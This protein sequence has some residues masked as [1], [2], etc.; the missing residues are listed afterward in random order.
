MT[1]RNY[2][3]RLKAVGFN[4]MVPRAQLIAR[5]NE[6]ERERQVAREK[7]IAREKRILRSQ[8]KRF[9]INYKKEQPDDDK[10]YTELMEKFNKQQTPPVNI[11]YLKPVEARWNGNKKMEIDIQ[12]SGIIKIK[13][14]KPINNGDFLKVNSNDLWKSYP[15]IVLKSI[16]EKMNVSN[17]IDGSDYWNDDDND[18]LVDVNDNGYLIGY[19]ASDKINVSIFSQNI[20]SLNK[21]QMRKYEYKLPHK[22]ID[23]FIDSGD[24][25]CFSEWFCQKY[26]KDG[27]FIKMTP[28]KLDLKFNISNGWTMEDI[29]RLAETYDISFYGLDYNETLITRRVSKNSNYKPICGII[30]SNHWYGISDV[31]FINEIR[32]KNISSN[33]TPKNKIDDIKETNTVELDNVIN[34]QNLNNEFTEMIEK[35]TIPNVFKINHNIVMIDDG[36]KKIYANENK[37]MIIRDIDLINEM[38]ETNLKFTNQPIQ[39]LTIKLFEKMNPTFEKSRYNDSVDALFCQN[40]RGGIN[41]TY[42]MPVENKKLTAV[43]FIKCYTNMAINMRYDYP[44]VTEDCEI[45]PYDGTIVDGFLYIEAPC[46]LPFNGHGLYSMSFINEVNKMGLSYTPI[47]QIKT[48]KSIDK[49]IISNFI[50]KLLILPNFKLYVNS[51]IGNLSKTKSK[52]TYVKYTTSLEECSYHFK[53]PPLG[54]EVEIKKAFDNLHEI[55]FIKKTKINEDSRPINRQIIEFSYL[56]AYKLSQK[57]G[58][59]LIKIKTDELTFENPNWL[60]KPLKDIQIDRTKSNDDIIHQVIGSIS[61]FKVY[62]IPPFENIN[63]GT[64][65]TKASQSVNIRD[66]TKWKESE[67]YDES[68]YMTDRIVEHLLKIDGAMITGSAGTGKS[69]IIKKLSEKISNDKKKFIRCSFTNK[70]SA[71]INGQTIHKSFNVKDGLLR[72]NKTTTHYDYIILDE[73]SMIPLELWS[74]IKFYKKKYGCI[75]IGFGD[76][77]QLPPVEQRKIDYENNQMLKEIFGYSNVELEY[78]KRQKNKKLIDK[79][80]DILQNGEFCLTDFKQTNNILNLCYLNTTSIKINNHYNNLIDKP[81]EHIKAK[82][83]VNNNKKYE[84]DAYLAVGTPIIFCCSKKNTPINKGQ[85]AIIESINVE[86]KTIS[87]NINNSTILFEFNDIYKYINLAYCMTIHK[88]QGTT[89]EQPYTIH[90]IKYMMNLDIGRQLLYVALTRAADYDLISLMI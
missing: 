58:G 4:R 9:V 78:V 5:E 20:Q 42:N 67:F 70:A 39:N 60:P 21:I 17:Y 25:K 57:C 34:K 73:I 32:R 1:V 22:Q 89:I 45:Q 74:I 30:N 59:R 86:K 46:E 56:E 72:N 24:G 12:N 29:M 64:K 55:S 23:N 69:Y 79:A 10:R 47:Y 52:N 63:G 54:E 40:P 31:K 62:D 43:D 16:S 81:K 38:F 51:F 27:K 26:Q 80:I 33:I 15:E 6:V 14:T 84:S 49:K 50:K 66:W 35:K 44:I 19:I 18:G 90:D 77:K 7:Q 3:L 75:V 13:T 37:D 88:S 2:W 68:E 83:I 85:T 76:F 87:I 48:F 71:L 53:N 36:N 11:V 82:I 41:Q 28:D 8:M 61:G 65:E